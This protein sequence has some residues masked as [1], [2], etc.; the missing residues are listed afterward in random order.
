MMFVKLAFSS[1][2]YFTCTSQG[3]FPDTAQ[4]GIGKYFYCQQA[5]GGRFFKSLF[6]RRNSSRFRLAPVSASCPE[7]QRFNRFTNQCDSAYQC[8]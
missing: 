7:G 5:T 6:H 1:I 2:G 8:T 4:C 3:I